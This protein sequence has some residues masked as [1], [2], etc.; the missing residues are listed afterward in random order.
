LLSPKKP[1]ALLLNTDTVQEGVASGLHPVCP[2]R[3]YSIISG[4]DE[5][6]FSSH[7]FCPTEI[8]RE[9]MHRID[10]SI[11]LLRVCA[12]RAEETAKEVEFDYGCRSLP[13]GWMLPAAKALDISL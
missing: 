8:L 9:D 11:L 1:E 10:D 12:V 2:S 13:A 7:D 6:R 5:L 4:I 3:A